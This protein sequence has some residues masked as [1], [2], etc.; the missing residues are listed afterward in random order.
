MLW[1]IGLALVLVLATPLV[2]VL[3]FVGAVAVALDKV[4]VV[5]EDD[6]VHVSPRSAP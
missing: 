4:E 1:R 3:W 6:T 5:I 2:V